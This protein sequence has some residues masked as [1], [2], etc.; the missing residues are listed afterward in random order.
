MRLPLTMICL[1]AAAL[2]ARAQKPT[3]TPA[4][5]LTTLSGRTYKH[6]R[7]QRVEPD[8]ITYMYDGGMSKVEFSDL[9]EAIRTQYGYDPAKAKAFAAADAEEQGATSSLR[10]S[11]AAAARE[12]QQAMHEAAAK[13]IAAM[14]KSPG[15][16]S[17]S[18]MLEQ[19]SQSR[20]PVNGRVLQVMDEGIRIKSERGEVIVAG[21]PKQ[22]SV[23]E[24][25][26]CHFI[27]SDSGAVAYTTV[28]GARRQLAKY[29]YIS[30]H[31]EK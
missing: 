26:R 19:P 5:D 6:A 11:E 16:G 10:Q 30:G 27:A 8:G 2:T 22:D 17:S 28:M 21:Y 31:V 29:T 14:P 13:D 3:P 25:N 18:T 15:V 7:V 24:G 9:P 20:I 1:C 4:P 12:Q 23:A